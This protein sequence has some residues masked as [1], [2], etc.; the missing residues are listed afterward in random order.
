MSTDQTSAI[1]EVLNTALGPIADI[2]DDK[3]VTEVMVNADGRVWVER[4]GEITD[5]GKVMTETN[6][7]HVLSAIAKLG[8]KYAKERTNSALVGASIDGYRYAGTLKPVDP[9]GSTM[10]IR[11]HADPSARLT[12]DQLVDSGSITRKWAD[13]LVDQIIHKQRNC[14]FI[15]RTSSGKTTLAN[16][17]LAQLP[18]TER[19]VTIEDAKELAVMVPNRNEYMIN[20]AEGIAAQDL[21]REALR[22]RY[23]RLIVGETRGFDTFDL[24]RGF[25]SGHP[26]S[27]STAHGD[28]CRDGLYAL[29]M[30]YQMSIPPGAQIPVA[31]SRQYIANAI[32]LLVF[33][34][35]YY[36][37]EQ[38]GVR[39]SV[40]KV[41]EIVNLNGVKDGQYDL[42]NYE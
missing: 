2:M 20:T 41:Q 19:V 22:E 4:R 42:E 27:I 40:R 10:S 12:M 36:V 5:S 3:S 13:Y 33:C 35:R 11:K 7:V 1:L 24:I 8:G 23:D 16:A 9:R 39:R 38:D 28:S 30:M 34:H 6:R 14:I 32:K 37:T 25:N 21:I 29:E 18:D 15:G 17:I 31:V 26:G